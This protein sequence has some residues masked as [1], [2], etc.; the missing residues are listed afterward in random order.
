MPLSDFV[1]ISKVALFIGSK[2]DV[3]L[4]VLEPYTKMLEQEQ[5][6]ELVDE[7]NEKVVTKHSVTAYT[8]YFKRSSIADEV[9]ACTHLEVKPI[10]YI[11]DNHKDVDTR[12]MLRRKGYT[13]VMMFS[14]GEGVSSSSGAGETRTDRLLECDTDNILVFGSIDDP[15]LNEIDGLEY[16]M[17]EAERRGKSFVSTPG[18]A[19]SNDECIQRER[20]IEKPLRVPR[21]V[22]FKAGKHV[23]PEI[24][25]FDER[26]F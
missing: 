1:S 7:A 17:R 18:I 26:A 5:F 22:K 14:I 24:K 3:D 19:R 13:D 4:S 11:R 2:S 8:H 25:R 21:T 16:V 6:D 23:R 20:G 15:T 9:N 10:V 12:I